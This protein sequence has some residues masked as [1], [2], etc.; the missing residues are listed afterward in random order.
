M[1]KDLPE[2]FLSDLY[3]MIKVLLV[4]G[5]IIKNFHDH[6]LLMYRAKITEIK[7]YRDKSIITIG[8][9]NLDIVL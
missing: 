3:T 2:I 4:Q 6:R 1:L 7:A 8:D 9:I 5:V